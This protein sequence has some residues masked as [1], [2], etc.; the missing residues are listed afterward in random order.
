MLFHSHFIAGRYTQTHVQSI[1]LN[2]HLTPLNTNMWPRYSQI[3]LCPTE[4]PLFKLENL[5]PQSRTQWWSPQDVSVCVREIQTQHNPCSPHLH[6]FHHLHHR[7]LTDMMYAQRSPPHDE[8]G[9]A[10]MN[11]GS[12]LN[13]ITL[14]PSLNNEV[15]NKCR[16][17]EHLFFGLLS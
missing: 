10:L 8:C 11:V 16:R 9:V 15:Q 7:G 4:K 3:Q 17:S 2:P 1:H 14:A 6:R 5:N 12:T 13:D